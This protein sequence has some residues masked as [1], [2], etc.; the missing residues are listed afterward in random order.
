MRSGPSPL[1]THVTATH[2]FIGSLNV[3]ARR[4]TENTRSPKVFDKMVL[5]VDGSP[6]S[7]AAV[8]TAIGFA[9]KMGAHVEVVHVREHDRILSKAGSGPDL[10]TPEDANALLAGVV[11]KL[12]KAGVGV[13]ATLRQAPRHDVAGEI[14][15]V[16]DEVG[17]E[18]IVVGSRGLSAFSETVL[19]SVSHKLVLHAGRPV[20]VAHE[21]AHHAAAAAARA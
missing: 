20:L 8:D 14:V 4:A 5:A 3:S 12:T 21:P 19:G 1:A 2:A 13:H 10:E 18:F 9:S 7:N 15:S 11:T 6:S 16:A 17:A